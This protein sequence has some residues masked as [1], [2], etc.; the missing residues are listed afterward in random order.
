LRCKISL[1][2]AV[3]AT[4]TNEQA[5]GLGNAR[6]PLEDFANYFVNAPHMLCLKVRNHSW[7]QSGFPQP[8]ETNRR[9]AKGAKYDSQGQARSASP[10]VIG[11]QLKRALK[12]RNIVAI[13]TLFQS[14]T[15][16]Y[17]RDPGATRFALAPGYRESIEESTEGAK[18]HRDYYALSELHG[19]LR[20]DPGATRFALA[21]GYHIPRLWRCADSF[22]II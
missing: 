7:A 6:P 20:T 2:A 8:S 19:C 12:V 10:L 3:D 14:F 11:N 22:P 21:P 4:D 5:A 13:I 18:Y 16:V 15:V 17:A 9:S 1:P